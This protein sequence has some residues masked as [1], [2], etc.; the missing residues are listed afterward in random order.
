MTQINLL[1]TQLL[2]C[3]IKTNHIN[4]YIKKK[5]YKMLITQ[6]FTVCQSNPLKY[7]KL[8]AITNFVIFVTTI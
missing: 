8:N 6:F 3:N 5:T 7:N 4:N 1:L 2:L